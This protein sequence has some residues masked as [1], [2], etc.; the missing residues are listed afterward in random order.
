MGPI[1]DTRIAALPDAWREWPT[2]RI[3]STNL[4]MVVVPVAVLA[5][6]FGLLL[7][8]TSFGRGVFEIGLSAEAAHFSGVEVRRTKLLLFVM[9]GLVASLPLLGARAKEGRRRLKEIAGVVPSVA[10]F[11]HGCRF[12]PRCGRASDL[13]R[14]EDPAPTPLPTTNLSPRRW[15][16]SMWKRATQPTPKP[17]RCF[18]RTQS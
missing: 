15:R 10:G 17:N 14:E 7:H 12:H 18:S 5:I 2:E 13:C 3:G 4:P 16:H 11:P 8:F 1:Q 6:L 9:S